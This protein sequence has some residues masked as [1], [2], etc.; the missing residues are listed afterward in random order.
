MR[1]AFA[2]SAVLLTG[3]SFTTGAFKTECTTKE[4][5]EGGQVCTEG[6][7]IGNTVPPGCGE[8]FGAVDAQNAIHVGAALGV[9]VDAQGNQ[10]QLEVAGL[11]AMKLA[12]DEINQRTVAGRSIVLHYCDTFA[13]AERIKAQTDWLVKDRGAVAIF[14]SGSGQTI[15]ASTVTIPTSTVIMT[16]T[17]TSPEITSLRA[18]NAGSARLVWRTAPS[19]AIQ[20]KA[21]AQLLTLPRYTGANKVG[22]IYV[23]DPYGQGLKDVLQAEITAPRTVDTFQFDAAGSV[24]AAVAALNAINPDITVVVGLKD[25]V[26]DI[27]RAANAISGS[28]LVKPGHR[29]FFTDSAKDPALMADL[30]ALASE[31][32]GAEGTAPAQGAGQAYT[33]F[34]DAYR[35]RFT[36]D[37][38]TIAFTSHAYDAM[39]LVALAAAH[40]AKDGSGTVNGA[41][42]ATGLTRLSDTSKQPI[43][44]SPSQFTGATSELAAGRNINVDGAS[45]KLD[46]DS[47][48]GEAVSPIEVWQV[49]GQT[50]TTVTTIDP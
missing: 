14:T 17:S 43:R 20:G 8:K 15:A 19:D 29:W 11:N 2:L 16:A 48:T 38:G 18:T 50:F 6:F 30:G 5:C 23:N 21:V 35:S 9:T 49:S 46:F 25:N 28:N 37:P 47:A 13:D 26:V 41:A 39:Y 45:G 12:L 1:M 27:V 44:L 34:R 24:T 22:V 10:D 7:C 33:S 32:N 40:A 36:T 3:C 31:I 42:I 4:D